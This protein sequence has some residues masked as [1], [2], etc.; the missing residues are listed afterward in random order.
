MNTNIRTVH[1]IQSIDFIG[2]T[3]IFGHLGGA[4]SGVYYSVDK[5]Q[6]LDL[7]SAGLFIVHTEGN[8]QTNKNQ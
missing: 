7:G 4:T 1:S 8:K 2:S 3:S 5:S 6:V